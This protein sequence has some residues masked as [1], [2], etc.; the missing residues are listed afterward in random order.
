MVRLP[1][2]SGRVRG[3]SSPGGQPVVIDGST[4]GT[5][6]DQFPNRDLDR[7]A[8]QFERLHPLTAHDGA[9]RFN[10]GVVGDL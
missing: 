10:V 1:S 9:Q 4:K 6:V 7:L 8:L 5:R 3:A 2:R